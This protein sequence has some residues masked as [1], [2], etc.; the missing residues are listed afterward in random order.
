MLCS[1]AENGYQYLFASNMSQISLITIGPNNS[2]LSFIDNWYSN[3]LYP[4]FTSITIFNNYI[5]IKIYGNTTITSTLLC[6]QFT[7]EPY[8]PPPSIVKFFGA[9][10]YYNY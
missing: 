9:T 2:P 8:N 4:Q 6:I 7:P 5:Y 10:L 3:P 1:Y